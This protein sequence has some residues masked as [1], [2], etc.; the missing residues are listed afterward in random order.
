QPSPTLSGGEAQ[1]IKLARELAR[2]A[3]GR[4]LYVMDEPSTGLHVD[5]VRHLLSVVDRLVSLGNT[6]IM[7]EHNLEILKVADHLIDLGP[8]GGE[9]G[10]YVVAAGTPEQ[11]AALA[12]SHTGT[13]LRDVLG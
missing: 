12:D 6:V 8:E 5:D 3:T 2:V 10:G 1:R 9:E 11:V 4:T 7:I 13:A